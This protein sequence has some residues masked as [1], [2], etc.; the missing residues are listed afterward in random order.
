MEITVDYTRCQSLGICESIAPGTF[1]VDDDGNLHVQDNATDAN[2][3][4]IEEAVSSCPTRALG[5]R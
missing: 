1:Q 5:L 4:D 3:H 2:R